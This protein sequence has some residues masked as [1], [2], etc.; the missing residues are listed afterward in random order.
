[1]GALAFGIAPAASGGHY[2]Y[3]SG[4]TPWK[5]ANYYINYYNGAGGDY[6]N[7]YQEE[8]KTDSNAWSPYTDIYLNQVSAAGS[9]DH[10]NTYAGSYGA[11]GWLGLASIESNSGCT[12]LKGT[13]R[14]N[15]SYLDNGSY[16]R[17]NKKHVAC[18]E[19]GHL[20][21]LHHTS[22]TTCMNDQILNAPYPN[23][24]DRDAVNAIY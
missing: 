20:F 10:L 16:S 7:I 2:W 9:T 5:Y 12:I 22:G 18:Q 21:G 6:Y 11:T 24:H 23:S 15:K 17:T 4:S 8:S 3:C 19:V 1:M 14:L 13:A